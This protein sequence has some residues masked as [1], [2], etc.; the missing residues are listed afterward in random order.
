MRGQ[1]SGRFEDLRQLVEKWLTDKEDET[2]RF[3]PVAVSEDLLAE[4]L[5]Q[6]Q[7]RLVDDAFLYL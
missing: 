3:E 7:V 5:Q 4:Q 1:T 2:E 6:I